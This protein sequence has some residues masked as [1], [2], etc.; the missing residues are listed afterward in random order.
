MQGSKKKVS[1]CFGSKKKV[2][3]FALEIGRTPKGS[4]RRR[5]EGRSDLSILKSGYKS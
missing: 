4:Y 3:T 1:K 2:S 5:T